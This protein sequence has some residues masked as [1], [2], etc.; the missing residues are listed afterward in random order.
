MSLSGTD[1]STLNIGNGGT[2]VASAYTDTT[3][4]SNI[5]S[6]TLAN[7]RLPTVMTGQ[8]YN[9]LTNEALSIG[10]SVAGGTT[11][12]TL[13]VSNSISLSGTDGS[14][15]NVGSGGSL[16]ASAYTDT[17]NASNI[18][19]GTLSNSHLPSVLTGQTYNGLSN[20]ALGTGFTI[21]GGTTSKTLTV[22]NNITIAGVDGSTVATLD[23]N[24]GK[25]AISQMPEIAIVSFLGTV[26]SQSAMTT[27]GTPPTGLPTGTVGDWC[28]RSD[29][30]TTW[31]LTAV[32]QT[33][34]ANWTQLSY[35][36]SSVLTV[37][38]RTGSVVL[39]ASD[40][41]GLAASATTD[42]TNASNITSG[43]L[44][45]ARLPTVLTGQ[46][47][48]GLTNTANAV[49][50]SVAGGT[51]SKTLTV[52]NTL[53][54]AGT[55]SSTLNVGNG[56]TLVAS[57][58]TDTTNASNIS[59]GTL[60]NSRLPTVL[61]GQTY[62]GL[63][64]TP[65]STGFS[66]AGG[67]T[68]KT[69]TVNNTLSLSGTDSSTLNIGGG[70]TLVASAFTNALNASNI[71]SGTLAVAN[72]G[73]G[74]G[75]ASIT[76][77][78]NITGYTASGATGTTS[79]NLVFSTNPTVTT[80]N[81]VGVSNASSANAGS[82]GEVISATV[83]VGSAVSLTSGTAANITSISLTAGDWDVYGRVA[84]N[85]AG[86]THLSAITSSINTTSATVA[87]ASTISGSV[88]QLQLTFT[89]GSQQILDAGTCQIN[90][91]TTT[92]VYLVGLAT[93]NTSTCSAFGAMSARRRR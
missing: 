71:S 93:F 48:N 4:A 1:S 10:F 92:T 84:F 60:S 31:L 73:T 14:T 16:V 36:P 61:T 46:T 18:T 9:G 83:V 44:G 55:D 64:N 41:G 11:S 63:T 56:G 15:L 23:S 72:G 76:A 28:I 13:T 24:T 38:G 67:T 89:N 29:L 51:T 32:P 7:A 21:A 86:P 85:P 70:G 35:A 5:N 87:L 79:T 22:S 59:S 42:T 33:T 53:T 43:T 47:Y 6:G 52:A 37:A 49:G 26:G 2:L 12:K 40:I 17:T 77:F 88:S 68:S 30:G 45:N 75:T 19:T 78:N 8:T 50:F 82:V 20:T 66:I 65:N 91:S 34:F 39:T 74:T 54:L 69:L 62:N 57:A 80:P 58:F 3:N 90:I 81:I 25:L 27:I